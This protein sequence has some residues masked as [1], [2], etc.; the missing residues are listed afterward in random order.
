[1]EMQTH[2]DA[3]QLHLHTYYIIPGIQWLD[4]WPVLLTLAHGPN[5][6]EEHT[7]AA[8]VCV[9]AGFSVCVQF[10]PTCAGCSHGKD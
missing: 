2:L 3:R 5:L 4:V 1:M 9:R 10:T 6:T 7:Y 8:G